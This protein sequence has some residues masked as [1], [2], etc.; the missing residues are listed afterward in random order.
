MPRKVDTTKVENADFKKALGRVIVKLRR[1]R[2]LS[3]EQL[4][5]TAEIDRTFMSQLERGEVNVS[6]DTLIKVAQVLG[7]TLGSLT[8]Q[9]ERNSNSSPDAAT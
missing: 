4:A 8:T 5:L 2:G 9:A 3:Q 1:E 6:I 7:Q